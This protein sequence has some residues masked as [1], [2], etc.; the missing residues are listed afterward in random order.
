M[1]RDT[2]QRNVICQEL[3][4]LGNHPTADQVYNAVHEKYPRI[5]RATVYRTLNRLSDEGLVTR[6]KVSDGADR[7]DHQ[8]QQHY[9]VRCAQCGR[10]ADVNMPNLSLL[11]TEAARLSGYVVEG[12]SL[13]FEGLCPGCARESEMEDADA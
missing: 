10:V 13:L 8:T 9:H 6:V 12:H 4:N 2:M 11:D 5:S 3:N 1:A 7:F